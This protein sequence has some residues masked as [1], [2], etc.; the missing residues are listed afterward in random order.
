MKPDSA[1]WKTVKEQNLFFYK[2]LH[3]DTY[4]V[5]VVVV[6]VTRTNGASQEKARSAKHKREE[7]DQCKDTGRK[8]MKRMV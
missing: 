1:N 8:A 6:I 3:N 5:L 2:N 4:L 7:D